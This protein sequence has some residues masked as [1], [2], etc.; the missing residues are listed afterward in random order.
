[1]VRIFA[2]V[3]LFLS[4]VK[5]FQRGRLRKYLQNTRPGALFQEHLNEHTIT[6]QGLETVRNV[7][8]LETVVMSNVN[9]QL[10]HC[11]EKLNFAGDK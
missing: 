8:G 2:R 6:L 1:L 4:V 9:V 3:C 5:L 10:V 7:E 11:E